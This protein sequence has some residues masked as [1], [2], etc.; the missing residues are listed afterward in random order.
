METEELCGCKLHPLDPNIVYVLFN[1][2]KWHP[3]CAFKEANRKLSDSQDEIYDMSQQLE[4]LEIEHGTLLDNVKNTMC[5]SCGNIVGNEWSFHENQ[6][7]C[8]DCLNGIGEEGD[9]H[10]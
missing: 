3:I 6:I 2:L 7:V 5:N 4:M 1:K 8:T 10:Y 9:L